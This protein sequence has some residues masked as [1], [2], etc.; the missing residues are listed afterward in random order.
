M[1]W[2]H[3]AEFHVDCG[4]CSIFPKIMMHSWPI[5]WRLA[6]KLTWIIGEHRIHICFSP[7]WQFII[8]LWSPAF[9]KRLNILLKPFPGG[10]KETKEV[11]LA[12]GRQKFL[13]RFL[14]LL[15]HKNAI[16]WTW[17]NCIFSGLTGF[18]TVV[19]SAKLDAE[20]L[21][22]VSRL[23]NC[24][25]KNPSSLSSLPYSD[26]GWGQQTTGSAERPQG[27]FNFLPPSCECPV[28]SVD[29][30]GVSRMC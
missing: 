12:H 15:S 9:P 7:S 11:G 8:G 20:Q 26:R 3:R 4:Y 29:L 30:I 17:S 28:G 13:S 10:Y 16:L 24:L 5:L 22:R 14:S 6:R 18:R 23:Q 1:S 27:P 19:R 21:Q 2:Q 25:L